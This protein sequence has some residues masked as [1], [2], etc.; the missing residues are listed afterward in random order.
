MK[1]NFRRCV[2]CRAIAPKEALWRVVR[3]YPS[4]TVQLDKGMGRSAYLCPNAN[5]LKAAQKKN[6]LGRA[7]RAPVHE[8]VYEQLWQR[9]D[10]MPTESKKSP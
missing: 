2:S 1:P 9:L 6:R 7:L 10:T 8:S 3:V 5:C 4:R